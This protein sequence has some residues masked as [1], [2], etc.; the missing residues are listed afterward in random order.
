MVSDRWVSRAGRSLAVIVAVSALTIAPT[1]PADTV[2]RSSG[3]SGHGRG[4]LTR[5][6]PITFAEAARQ[7]REHPRAHR[8]LPGRRPTIRVP[9]RPP[10]ADTALQPSAG[11]TA[12]AAPPAP[13]VTTE[14]VG[15]D[16]ATAGFDP[17][18][19][20][21]TVNAGFVIQSVNGL[22]QVSSRSG[23]AIQQ[24]PTWA[25]FGIPLGQNESDPRFLWDASHA[26]WVGSVVS[27]D[28]TFTN[29]F[30]V[31]AVSETADPLGAWDRYVFADAVG[32]LPDQPTIASSTTKVVIPA[33]EFVNGASVYVGASILA[34]DWAS[35][36]NGGALT[37]IWTADNGALWSIRPAQVLSPSSDVHLIAEATGAG[38]SGFA[39][40]DIL[41]KRLTGTAGPTTTAGFVELATTHGPFFPI[42][43]PRQSGSPS[44]VC[45]MYCDERPTDVVSRGSYLWVVSTSGCL[46]GANH[47]AD[48]V[49]AV[50]LNTAAAG[51]P[52]LAADLLIGEDAA[53]LF[54]GGLTI[55]GDGTVFLAYSRSSASDFVSA[56]ARV[57][58]LAGG[59]GPEQGLADGEGTYDPG[60]SPGRWGDYLGV[61][62]DP[63]GTGAAWVGSEIPAADG[64]WR[65]V[66]TRLVVDSTP[67]TVTIPTLAI[68]A[69]AGLPANTV[70]VRVTWTGSDPGSGI[71]RY[72]VSES[73]DGGATLEPAITVVGASTIVRSAQIGSHLGFVVVAVDAAGNTSAP[74]TGPI[75]T[76]TLY[77]QTTGTV[78]STGWTTVSRAVYSGGSARAASV[79][80]KSVT[81]SFAGRS[82]GFLSYKSSTRG[83]V[84][85]Y[86]DGV[87]RK[88]VSLYSA[89]V[90]ARQLVFSY[91]WPAYGSHK[92]KLVVVGTAGHPRVDVDGFVVLK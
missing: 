83:S 14:F 4:A 82:V 61:A 66:V 45:S 36:I 49:R 18:D 63:S 9:G 55:A 81:F 43:P 78:Y 21:V 10:R 87:Y 52:T 59:L 20:W 39:E 68:V 25:V 7:G 33:N 32:E 65:T 2:A 29:N 22:V 92:L 28:G 38:G 56:K 50:G 16:E 15:L 41:Y 24:A 1:L 74:A 71:D 58:T 79:A 17:P 48:C 8:H 31:L 84:R 46:D 89:T 75:F 26:R 69:P 51:P 34:I 62:A 40:G 5:L 30:I 44:T 67:P 47:D 91:S 70:P 73:R 86:V 54:M 88:T 12:L 85:I 64:S 42:N 60:S 53:D 3:I 90:R 80:G 77:Q 57:F 72:L 37:G 6:G 23:V 11:S 19:G 27:F 13:Q 35:I 76:P